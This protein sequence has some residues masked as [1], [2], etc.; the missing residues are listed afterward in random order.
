MNYCHY[1]SQ[2]NVSIPQKLYQFPLSRYWRY[3]SKFLFS[4]TNKLNLSQS[5]QY[6]LYNILGITIYKLTYGISKAGCVRF[7]FR[8]YEDK[9]AA[10]TLTCTTLKTALMWQPRRL[11]W[12]RARNQT[13]CK[14][15]PECR[16]R[17]ATHMQLI[18]VTVFKRGSK[19]RIGRF[20]LISV[21]SKKLKER[22]QRQ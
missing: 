17:L 20:F 14:Y 6:Q 22:I 2:R 10:E 9:T 1:V 13:G 3:V 12:S 15:L 11:Y 7:K 8:R 18:S 19:L 16:A 5:A 21:N 4:G